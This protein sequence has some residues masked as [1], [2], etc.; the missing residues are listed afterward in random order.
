MLANGQ[1]SYGSADSC[2]S[3]RRFL[4]GET[5]VAGETWLCPC[6]LAALTS[7]GEAHGIAIDWVTGRSG[8]RALVPESGLNVQSGHRQCLRV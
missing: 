2:G 4:P 8:L 5:W 6:R 7:G 3:D 1:S